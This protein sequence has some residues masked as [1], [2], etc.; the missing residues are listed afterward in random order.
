MARTFSQSQRRA[1]PER[2]SLA[3]DPA[4]DGGRPRVVTHRHAQHLVD[5]DSDGLA[6]TARLAEQDAG[7]TFTLAWELAYRN[8][9]TF[10]KLTSLERYTAFLAWIDAELAEGAAV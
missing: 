5:E 6:E 2:G 9:K 8:D 1:G 10:S 7:L 3:P 4:G